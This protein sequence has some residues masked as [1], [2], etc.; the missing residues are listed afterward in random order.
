MLLPHRLLQQLHQLCK[1]PG[2]QH[3]ILFEPTPPGLPH[4]KAKVAKITD[5]VSHKACLITYVS[6]AGTSAHLYCYDDGKVARPSPA[7]QTQP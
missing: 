1:R 6:T 4:P 7:G 2:I 5:T 3:V